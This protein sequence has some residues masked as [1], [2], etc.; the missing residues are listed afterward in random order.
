MRTLYGRRTLI[1][2]L[3]WTILAAA[4][5]LIERFFP[6]LLP[7]PSGVSV[8]RF[9]VV[10]FGALALGRLL[11]LTITRVLVLREKPVVEGRMIG[12]VLGLIT[13]IAVVLI[14]AWALGR[15]SSFGTVF[16][17]F[18]GMVIGWSLQAPVSGFAAWI[19]VSLK[20]PFRP[21]DR[22][23]FP[24]LELTGDLLDVGAMYTTLDQ[25]GGSIGSEEAV[26][27]TIL[28]PNAMLF[29]EVVINYTVGQARPYMLDEV[30]VRITYD[31]NWDTA[32]KILIGAAREI[33]GDIIAETG[34]QPY[35][36]SDLYDY[37][38]YLQLRYQ[39]HVNGRAEIAYRIQKRIFEEIQRDPTVDIAI[40]FIYSYRA[41]RDMKEPGAP[42][43]GRALQEVQDIDL[44]S[45]HTPRV[46]AD[47]QDLE[48]L[49]KSIAVHGLLEP[50]IVQ[51]NPRQGLGAPYEILTGN[52]RVEA[53][54]KLGWKTI[55]A[56][57]R[58]WRGDDAVARPADAPDR[59]KKEG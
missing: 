46:R 23:Q 12:R 44:E 19:M 17:L 26:G 36:R 15:L 35:I 8:F 1:V 9:G 56:I 50:V 53:C 25:V 10:A 7:L 39:T 32:E 58:P 34:V 45:I 13:W 41:G 20:R 47:A 43:E 21:G 24:K 40:P 14:G 18:G 59:E 49:V 54:R 37:G 27:R 57:I 33:T 2:F 16:S 3:V 22:I 29:D 4:C 48:Q 6:A 28:V 51:K 42:V 52:L 38:V 11:S 31:S 55:P 5:L 30:V